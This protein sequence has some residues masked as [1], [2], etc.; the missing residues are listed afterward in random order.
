[1]SCIVHAG[2]AYRRP[3]LGLGGSAGEGFGNNGIMQPN[4]A[5]SRLVHEIGF[6][7]YPYPA[8]LTVISPS[9]FSLQW[10]KITAA[11]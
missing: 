4:V 5:F 7:Y 8:S 3:A 6:Q 1:M 10:L 11:H 9:V 2:F